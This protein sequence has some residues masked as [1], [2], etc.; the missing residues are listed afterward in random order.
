MSVNN[1]LY[2]CTDSLSD[3]M[4]WYLGN[5]F[6]G[7]WISCLSGPDGTKIDFLCDF[8]RMDKESECIPVKSLVGVVPLF[9]VSSISME[10]LNRYSNLRKAALEIIENSKKSAQYC[11]VSMRHVCINNKIEAW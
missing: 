5:L 1:C 8:F 6:P 3:F 2:T 10:T 4:A 11:G 7:L 9:A